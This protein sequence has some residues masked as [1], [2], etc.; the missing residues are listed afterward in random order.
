MN[1][2]NNFYLIISSNNTWNVSCAAGKKKAIAF[3]F[4]SQKGWCHMAS[5]Q[6]LHSSDDS[7]LLV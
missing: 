2:E 5:I 1:I 6:H 3:T 4:L 7:T